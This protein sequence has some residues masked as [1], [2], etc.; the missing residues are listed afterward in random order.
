[1][2]DHFGS[3]WWQIKCS[4][5]ERIGWK[6][7]L[8]KEKILETRIY[9]FSNFFFFKKASSTASFKGEIQSFTFSTSTFMKQILKIGVNFEARLEL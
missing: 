6:T 2:L 1:M 7:F 8:E 9:P 3:I 4:W 5:D